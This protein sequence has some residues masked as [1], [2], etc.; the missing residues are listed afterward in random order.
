M[1]EFAQGDQGEVTRES[2]L[3]I[4]GG[5]VGRFVEA[6]DAEVAAI[7]DE[8]IEEQLTAVMARAQI[9]TESGN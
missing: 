4:G 8:H 3:A 2:L 6:V 5:A 9:Q 7:T 1:S